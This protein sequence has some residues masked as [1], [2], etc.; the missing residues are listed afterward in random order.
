V[1]AA[2]QATVIN[3]A[4]LRIP[5]DQIMPGLNARGDLGDLR[6]LATSLR[7]LGQ[8]K[9]LIVVRL[10]DGRYQILDGHRRHAA[11]QLAGVPHLDAVLRTDRGAAFRLQQQLAL[12][13]HARQFDPIAEARALHTLMFEHNLTRDQIA[14]TI[15]RPGMWVRNRIALIHLTPDEQDRVVQGELSIG[16]AL[17]ILASRRAG[18]ANPRQRKVATKAANTAAVQAGKHCVTCR[19]NVSA[20]DRSH[21][22]DQ[23]AVAS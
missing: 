11:A 17:R 14:A 2:D 20:S 1:T 7:N 8:Q 9:P 22:E 3:G 5:T 10:A 16:E 4:L 12:H 6:D 13:T 18:Y 23:R 21:F 19:C 15:G